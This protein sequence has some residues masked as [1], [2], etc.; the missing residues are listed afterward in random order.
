VSVDASFTPGYTTLAT[1]YL[2]QR[3]IDEA[4]AEFEG[5][6]QRDPSAVSAR[7]M[8]G[9]LLEMQGKRAEARSW[10]ERTMSATPNAPVA[11][12]NL[13]FIYAEEGSNLDMALQLAQ[14]AKQALPN[15]GSVDDT[16]GWVYYK[17]NLPSLA[18]GPLQESVKKLPDSAEALYHLGMVYLKLD[19]KP[20]ARETLERALK[21]DPKV[22]GDAARQAL[23][24]A[25][26]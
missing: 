17:R 1:L 15:D 26:R 24:T 9:M 18:V 7:T 13:A 16:L 20:R 10:Y 21:L 6:V 14:S 2:R 19:D 3:R 8:V 5:M 12:N 25:S 23:A 11:A 4:R 22:G